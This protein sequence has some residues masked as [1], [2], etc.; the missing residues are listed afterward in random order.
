MSEQVQANNWSLAQSITFSIPL[1]PASLQLLRLLAEVDCHRCLYQGPAVSRAIQRYEECWLPLLDEFSKHG[2]TL[3]LQP[4][5]DCAWIWH[6]HRL[7]PTIYARDCNLL[8]GRVLDAPQSAQETTDATE[9]TRLVWEERFPQ[10]NYFLD[11]TLY[12][13][14]D[15]WTPPADTIES[16]KIKYNLEEAVLRQKT[17]YYQ[18]SQPHM[19]EENFLRVAEQR[20]KGF[21]HLFR[22]TN[23]KVFLVP[24]YDIDLMWHAHQMNPIAYREDLTNILG[25]VLEHDD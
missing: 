12:H 17:F 9:T 3:P 4:P 1:V 24:T 22:T 14:E 6:C 7:N 25:R 13:Q 8:F 2:S 20:Y 5:L 15:Q 21:L 18:V 16:H 10:E 11:L 23:F 19:K